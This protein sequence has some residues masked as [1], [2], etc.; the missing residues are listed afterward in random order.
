MTLNK[1]RKAYL[2][3]AKPKKLRKPKDFD[4][5]KEDFGYAWIEINQITES[6]IF[7]GC[8]PMTLKQAKR[9]VKWLEKACEYLEAKKKK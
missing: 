1:I 3:K 5:T 2:R 7:V 9:L 4:R 6:R 8:D